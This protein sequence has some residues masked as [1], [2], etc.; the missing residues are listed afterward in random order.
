MKN[1]R[2]ICLNKTDSIQKA[3]EIIDQGSLQIALV[4][5]EDNQLLGTITDGDIRRALLKHI[6]LNDSVSKIM[7]ANPISITI[8]EDKNK[9]LSVMEKN[10]LLHIPLIDDNNMLVGLETLQQ[11]IQKKQYDNPV[12]L[13]AGGFGS[14]LRPMTEDTPKPMLRLGNQPILENIIKS[15]IEYGFKNFYISVHYLAEKIINYFGD[16]SAWGIKINYIHENKPLGTAGALS[17]LPK[18]LPNLQIIMMNSDI[19]TKVNFEHLLN[20]HEEASNNC[21][22]MCVRRYDFQVPYGVVEANADT[23]ISIKEKPIHNFFV[24]AGIYVLQPE[25]VQDFQLEQYCDMPALLNTLID[26][27]KTVSMFPIHEYWL[28][29][30]QSEDF[31]K[32]EKEYLNYF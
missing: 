20:F 28:D 13:M 30:G 15:F 8:N 25:I 14:R 26:K 31:C 24:N 18:D 10:K 2:E 17:L 22:T 16:G 12:F 11:L 7:N 6:S 3:I 1:W 27:E 19:L 32:A 5:T 9:I 21:A 4:I 23:I 29:I